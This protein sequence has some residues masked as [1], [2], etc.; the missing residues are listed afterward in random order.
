MKNSRIERKN[1]GRKSYGLRRRNN[2]SLVACV[3]L[4]LQ[5]NG[6][7]YSSKDALIMKG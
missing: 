2:K 7:D 3:L 5:G 4:E 1:I 6:G